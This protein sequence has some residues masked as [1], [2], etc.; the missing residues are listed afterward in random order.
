MKVAFLNNI[1]TTEFSIFYQ[2]NEVKLMN[3]NLLKTWHNMTKLTKDN[4]DVEI[5]IRSTYCQVNV[6]KKWN[7]SL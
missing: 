4:N 3:L 7:R 5:E 6:G 1:L 2:Q